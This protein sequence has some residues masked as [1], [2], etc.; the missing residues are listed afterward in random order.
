MYNIQLWHWQNVLSLNYVKISQSLHVHS[1]HESPIAQ[2][3]SIQTRLVI[4]YLFVGHKFDSCWKDLDF[5]FPSMLLSLAE[6]ILLQ[7][8]I[9]GMQKIKENFF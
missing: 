4:N 8:K 3:Y 9:I 1:F 7:Y 5:I 6:K 2:W